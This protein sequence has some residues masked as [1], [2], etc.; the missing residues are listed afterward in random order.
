M[1][2]LVT[3]DSS[4][5]AQAALAATLARD[6]PEATTIK[7]LTVLPEA[8]HDSGLTKVRSFAER[9]F[10]NQKRNELQ[11][12]FPNATVHAQVARGDK[13]TQILENANAWPADLIIVPADDRVGFAR[14][15]RKS[16]SERVFE[17]ASC[18]VIIARDR[19]SLT[20]V[21]NGGEPETTN[22]NNVLIALDEDSVNA[23]LLLAV[24][25][26]STW[27]EP[28]NIHVLTV[29][30]PISYAVGTFE[31]GMAALSSIDALEKNITTIARSTEQARRELE[32]R[33]RSKSHHLT[34][35]HSVEQGDPVETIL[36]F[37][38]RKNIDLIM[39]G[40]SG[41]SEFKRKLL[42]SISQAVASKAN[43]SVQIVR[44]SV[45]PLTNRHT[46]QVPTSTLRQFVSNA[47]SRAS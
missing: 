42:G 6:W 16:V 9:I 41:K 20:S 26:S 2:I 4:P 8:H 31:N 46:E 47:L 40:T 19:V 35:F 13:T 38:K 39:V 10:L 15:F 11:A 21:N 32:W 14:F 22:A 29:V 45:T 37:A 24:A 25:A 12:K 34:V 18:S 28:A 43:C 30:E 33:F 7:L 1:N 44:S 3:I 23:N 36:D 27:T 5:A 17:R